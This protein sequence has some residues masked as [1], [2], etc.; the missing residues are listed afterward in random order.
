[1]LAQVFHEDAMAI[2][3]KVGKKLLKKATSSNKEK[4]C[5]KKSIKTYKIYIFKIL[6]QVHLN[7]GTRA[8]PWELLTVSST[9]FPRSLL[10]KLKADE[11]QEKTDD[12]ISG[13]SKLCEI[14]ASY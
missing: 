14:C 10:R 1:M 13:N 9:I 2:K 11:V 7:T 5:A 6:K 4:K 3:P 8:K 12:F